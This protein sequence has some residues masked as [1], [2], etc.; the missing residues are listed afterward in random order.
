M[1]AMQNDLASAVR[2]PDFEDAPEQPS[3]IATQPTTISSPFDMSRSFVAA[4]DCTMTARMRA[5]SLMFVALIIAAPLRAARANDSEAVLAGGTLTFKKSDGIAM[6]SEE[7]TLTP[8]QVDVAYV[9]RN[10]TAAD[11]KTLVAF[12]LAPYVSWEDEFADP[13]DPSW[14]RFGHFTVVV[15]GKPVKF[16][17]TAKVDDNPR[18]GSRVATVTHHWMQTFPAGKTL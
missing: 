4:A 6:E 17:T 18:D 16:E 5:G 13:H 14:N 12:P 15:D 10:T 1:I 2:P 7:L 9:F 8:H 11:I 3:A